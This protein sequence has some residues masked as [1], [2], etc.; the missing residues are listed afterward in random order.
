M[1]TAPGRCSVRRTHGTQNAPEEKKV[2]ENEHF[3]ALT[4][5]P[6]SS[7][8]Q[9]A[10]EGWKINRR[11]RFMSLSRI[12]QQAV[13]IEAST[14]QIESQWS[15]TG[16]Y[17]QEKRTTLTFCIKKGYVS[18][19]SSFRSKYSSPDSATQAIPWNEC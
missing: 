12:A 3:R 9:D 4:T 19:S 13:G 5:E 11:S 6:V 8:Q 10:F 15:G 14:A 1:V 18:P 2:G 17:S 7:A 16:S